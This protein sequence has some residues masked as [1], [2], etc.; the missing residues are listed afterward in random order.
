V[1]PFLA[2]N[3]MLRTDTKLVDTFCR[4][5]GT[6]PLSKRRKKDYEKKEPGVLVASSG[7][8]GKFEEFFGTLNIR[9]VRLI[10]KST[11]SA[12]VNISTKASLIL[13]II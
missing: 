12:A 3:L 8:N 5:S 10:I 4:C 13:G 1:S 6:A 2:F 7:S 9:Y 11:R